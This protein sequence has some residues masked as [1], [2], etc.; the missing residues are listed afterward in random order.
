MKVKILVQTGQTGLRLPGAIV[1]VNPKT[2]EH[3]V[4]FGWAE[5]LAKPK[6]KKAKK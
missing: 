2:A 5:K 4:K 3:W 1:D 6:K